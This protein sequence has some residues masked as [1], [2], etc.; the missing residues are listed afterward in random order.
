MAKSVSSM[1]SIGAWAYLLGL[2]LA[3]LA[4]AFAPSD[5]NIALVLGVLGLVVGFLNV[6]DKEVMMFLLSGIAWLA[7]ASSLSE[8]GTLLGQPWLTPIF[9]NVS[10]FVAPAVA[11]VAI[12]AVYDLSKD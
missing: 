8:M 6:G 5:V 2:L 12:K 1:A 4:G 3:V 9:N 7:S 10:V 11:L